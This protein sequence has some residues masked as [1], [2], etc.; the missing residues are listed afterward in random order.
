MFKYKK[1]HV[2]FILPPW[3]LWFLPCPG[4]RTQVKITISFSLPWKPSIVEIST[5]PIDGP[6]R[7]RKRF[8]RSFLCD[9]YGAMIP[10]P[11]RWLG[12]S[13]YKDSN[14]PRTYNA[15]ESYNRINAVYPKI[16]WMEWQLE[17]AEEIKRERERER[18]RE[19]ERQRDRELKS[20]NQG[21]TN[22]IS[23][24]HTCTLTHL[25]PVC[26]VMQYN[27]SKFSRWVYVVGFV[28]RTWFSYCMVRT[29]LALRAVKKGEEKKIGGRGR[30]REEEG[31]K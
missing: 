6:N 16:G 24:A 11:D 12:Y 19:T 14:K 25:R 4:A 10:T 21:K 17:S 20:G 26:Y 22:L 1:R 15:Y 5:F 23:V 7:S 29:E 8:L 13:S 3:L 30:G 27:R 31:R 28:V 9:L 2:H 18:E